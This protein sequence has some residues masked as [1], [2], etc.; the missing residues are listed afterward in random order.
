MCL[1]CIHMIEQALEPSPN[2]A[3][4]RSGTELHLFPAADERAF[5]FVLFGQL[6][7][8]Q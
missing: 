6:A 7:L 1:A 8:S 3:T 2:V 4:G 5:G